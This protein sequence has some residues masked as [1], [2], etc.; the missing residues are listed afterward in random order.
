[1]CLLDGIDHTCNLLDIVLLVE[2][3][4]LDTFSIPSD[5]LAGIHTI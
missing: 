3:Y 4:F 5:V 1:M 2:R